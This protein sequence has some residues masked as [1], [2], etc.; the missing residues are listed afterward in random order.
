MKSFAYCVSYALFMLNLLDYGN[1]LLQ[2][3]HV[4]VLAGFNI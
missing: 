1:I 4:D 2:N 3:G